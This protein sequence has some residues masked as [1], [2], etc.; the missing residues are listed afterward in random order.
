MRPP[1]P[2]VAIVGMSGIFPGSKNAAASWRAIVEGRD[3][4][5]DV[6]PTH[7]L[8]EDYLD[9]DPTVPDKIYT[10]RGAFLP[11]VDIDPVEFGIPPALFPS[12][13][14]SQLLALLA[15]RD[16]LND[17]TGGDLTRLNRERVAV[18]LGVTAGQKLYVE[19]SNRLQRPIWVKGLRESGVPESE[20]QA[21]C[22]R[23]SACYLPWTE[24]TFPG[25]L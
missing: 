9:P 15:A 24:S 16:V 10:A 25:S 13:D 5:T 4:F 22:D 18:I 17:A 11:L 19:M 3:L 14:T 20:V 7:W 21:I 12:T 1:F 2:P 6:P 8:I 23:I